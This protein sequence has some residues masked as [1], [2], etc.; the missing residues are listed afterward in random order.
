MKSPKKD[1]LQRELIAKTAKIT[2]MSYNDV[3]GVIDFYNRTISQNIQQDKPI[4]IHIDNIGR[5][6]FN[7][8]HFDKVATINAGKDKTTTGE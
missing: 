7:Q 4:D 1:A 3:E 2:D 8:K 6:E 5:F